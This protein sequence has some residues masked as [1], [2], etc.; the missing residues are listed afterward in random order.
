MH[1][2]Q[3][4]RIQAGD[5]CVMQGSVEEVF[6]PMSMTTI[7]TTRSAVSLGVMS[8]VETEAPV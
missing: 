7:A 3:S 1:A 2:H 8:P 5:S 6:A 4:P